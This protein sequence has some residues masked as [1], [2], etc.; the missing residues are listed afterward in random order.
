MAGQTG[1]VQR[2][3]HPCGLRGAYDF[4]P[5]PAEYARVD[6]MQAGRSVQQTNGGE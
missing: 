5:R 3:S 4:V 1:E 2:E 6:F